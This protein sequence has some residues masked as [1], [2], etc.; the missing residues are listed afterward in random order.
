MRKYIGVAL[1]IIAIIII[2]GVWYINS[3]YSSTTRTFSSYTLLDSAFQKYKAQFINSDGRV[4]D[5]SQ[6]SITTSEGQSYALLRA[7][8]TNDSTTFATVWNWTK[9]DLQH[10]NGDHLFEWRWGK[11]SDGSYGALSGGGNNS[12]TDADEDI[13]FALILAGHRW[14][15]KIYLDQAAQ[16]IPDI[17]KYETT[18]ANGKRYVTAGNWANSGNEVVMNPSYFAP[19]EYR[20]FAKIDTKDDWNSLIAPGYSMLDAVGSAAFNTGSGVG[21]PPDWFTMQKD[22]GTIKVASIPNADSNYSF[23]AMR[24]P[25]RVALD[26]FWNNNNAAKQ[27]L[28]TDYI[29]LLKQ[30]QLNKQLVS[31]YTHD[32]KPL[33]NNQNPDMY[34][35]SIGY[36]MIADT[37]VAQDIYNNKIIKLYS[38]DNNSFNSDLGYYEQNWLWF[39]AAMY[40]KALP[41]Y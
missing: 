34:A 41:Y 25:F 8:W 24:V 30:Y 18:Q 27:Y 13:A 36:F 19:Y 29:F 4:I 28:L 39:G 32:G 37:Q 21:L 31:G 11:R 1:I 14:N 10:K 35:T 20:I 6:G 16:I 7:V 33:D 22:N 5:Y 3:P 23:D 15:N 12:A 2:V 40:N 17:W 9:N 26:Y 38:N